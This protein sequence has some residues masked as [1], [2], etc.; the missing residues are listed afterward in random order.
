MG[1]DIHVH[2][3][4]LVVAHFHYLPIIFGVALLAFRA[5]KLAKFLWLALGS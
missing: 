3:K 4:Y 2:D 1:I 5:W